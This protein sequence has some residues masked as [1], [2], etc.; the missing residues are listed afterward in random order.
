M[1]DALREAVHAAR[2][3]RVRQENRNTAED[4]QKIL[5]RS[6]VGKLGAQARW[7][8]RVPQ[9]GTESEYRRH[10]CRCVECRRA[11][12]MG[13]KKRARSRKE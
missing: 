8:D 13:R 3:E 1:R 9:H 11:A 10:R 6:E 12:N 7:E 2:K 5:S 4:A